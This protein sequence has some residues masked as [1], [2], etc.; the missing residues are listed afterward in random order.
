MV[1][2]GRSRQT[3]RYTLRVEYVDAVR[4]AGGVAVIVP[5]GDDDPPLVLDRLDGI[6]LSG[7]GDVDP[8]LYGGE[9]HPAL[10]GIDPGRDATEIA[11]ARA[12][13]EQRIPILAICRGIQVVNVATGGDLF[14]HLPDVTSGTVHHWIDS[15]EGSRHRVRIAAD[16]RLA[17][18]CQAQEVM[19]QSWHHQALHRLG[20]GLRPVA[21]ADDGTLEAVESADHPELVAVQWHPEETAGTDPAQQHLFDWLVTSCLAAGP[22]G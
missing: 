21:W 22:L 16:S 18:I 1:S 4:R 8:R 20:E 2:S 7:G 13:L 11:L 5:P 17:A 15:A 6:I 3:E 10:Y 14:Q 19:V 12:A 9:P